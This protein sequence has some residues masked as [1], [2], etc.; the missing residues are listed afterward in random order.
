MLKTR[1]EIEDW[2]NKYDVYNAIINNDLTVDVT[3][4]LRLP[5]KGLVEIPIQFGTVHG[6]VYCGSN[7][8]KSL[9]GMPYRVKGHFNCS[10][11]ELINLDFCPQ[12]IGGQ[13]ICSH[14]PIESLTGFNSEISHLYHAYSFK[15]PHRIIEL[16][17]LY[18]PCKSNSDNEEFKVLVSQEELYKV[19]SYLELKENLPVKNNVI[20]KKN[21]I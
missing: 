11:N 9:K 2:L 5:N 4:D 20:T 21:K 14:N 17:D 7:K 16:K 13:L 15:D 1:E 12:F 8:L 18:Q 10:Y 6:T 19:L 3:R